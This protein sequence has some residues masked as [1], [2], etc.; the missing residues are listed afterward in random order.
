MGPAGVGKTCVALHLIHHE[1]VVARYFDRRYFVNCEAVTSVESL[2][3]L[4]MDVMD[5]APG[6]G[7]TYMA[8]LN[9]CLRASPPT[10]LL[11]DHLDAAWLQDADLGR[12]GIQVLLQQIAS[13]PSSS[14]IIT[15]RTTI[16]PPGIN[17]TF[18]G[19]ITSLSHAGASRALQTIL[20]LTVL[21][22]LGLLVFLLYKYKF[23][24][25]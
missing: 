2:A 17:W 24:K 18:S 7:E 20:A 12:S 13:T 25:A 19:A 9:R 14:L 15:T 1:L 22:V 23:H 11:L 8:A 6:T 4:I 16:A 5:L 10:L 21:V 3:S